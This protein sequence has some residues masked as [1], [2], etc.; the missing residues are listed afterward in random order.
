MNFEIQSK[1]VLC[2]AKQ[3][4]YPRRCVFCDDI[5][6]PYGKLI[7]S[8]CEKKIPYLTDPLCMKCGKQLDTDALFCFD[9]LKQSHFFDRGY[10]L[11][12]YHFVAE[13]LYRFKYG[14]RAEYGTFFGQ[15]IAKHYK[16]T[17]L[18]MKAEAIIPVPLH[19]T[20][21]RKRGYNQAELIAKEMGRELSIPVY[22]DLVKRRKKTI[23]QKEL[24][25][26]ARQNNLKKAF[27]I[28]ENVVKLRSIIIIDDI[29]TTGSTV[30]AIAEVLKDV[31]VERIHFFAIAIG[32]SI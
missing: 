25:Q 12:S 22:S 16:T 11:Y 30:N 29:Y 26:E 24:D 20:R 6:V 9:C 15:E 28:T 32:K 19:P 3:M 23:P 14:G 1:K 21:E 17:I 8:T 4:L 10:A 5:V 18:D 31:G 27:I 7:C 13:S 2:L